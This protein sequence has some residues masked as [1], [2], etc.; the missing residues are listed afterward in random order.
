MKLKVTRG[1]T[2]MATIEDRAGGA[3][4]KLEP[5]AKAGVNLEF[6]FAR[7]TPENPGKGL[8][9]VYPVKGAKAV[10]AAQEAGFAKSEAMHSV[11]FE[12]SDKPGM[13]ARIA[14]SLAA[15]GLSFRGLTATAVGKKFVGYVALDSADDAA[16]AAAALKKLA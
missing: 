9:V 10:R 16:R 2:W 13:T 3:A 8:M 12:G 1:E 7:R 11:R 15:A 14:R 4:D 6:A 5:F